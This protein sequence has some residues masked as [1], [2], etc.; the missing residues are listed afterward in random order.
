MPDL[1]ERR[2][3]VGELFKNLLVIAR[4]CGVDPYDFDR[5]DPQRLDRCR[6][7]WNCHG[8]ASF[9]GMGFKPKYSPKPPGGEL[10]PR[11]LDLLVHIIVLIG[12]LPGGGFAQNQPLL[13]QPRP[14]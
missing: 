8:R 5:P 3:V 10:K 12:D 2:A 6:I 7:L 9:P 4:R 14:G 11:C 1:R 13:E